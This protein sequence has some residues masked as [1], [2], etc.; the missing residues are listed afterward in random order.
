MKNIPKIKEVKPSKNYNIEV[1]FE[2]GI[3]KKYDIK[4]LMKQYPVFNDLKEN[5]LFKFVHVDC[6]GYGIAWNDYI[7][8]SEYEIWENGIEF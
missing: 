4:P 7:D 3:Q 8:L 6:G 5:N 2:N 1:M